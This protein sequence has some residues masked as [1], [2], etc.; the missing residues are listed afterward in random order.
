MADTVVLPSLIY[1]KI[2]SISFDQVAYQIINSTSGVQKAA[3]KISVF[4]TSHIDVQNLSKGVYVI[5]IELPH[6][7]EIHK[8][9]L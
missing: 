8:I 7:V 5:K 9:I 4:N 2:P 1:P 6:G 3:G